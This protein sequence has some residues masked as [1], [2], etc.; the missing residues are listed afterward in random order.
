M[1]RAAGASERAT[2]SVGMR[3]GCA[4]LLSAGGHAGTKCGYWAAASRSYSGTAD[5][6]MAATSITSP[7]FHSLGGL[8][9]NE[10]GATGSGPIWI[11]CSSTSRIIWCLMQSTC[12]MSMLLY[13]ELGSAVMNV[14]LPGSMRVV[15]HSVVRWIGQV[16]SRPATPCA[17]SVLSGTTGMPRRRQTGPCVAPRMRQEPS[18]CL[19]KPCCLR[20]C[21]AACSMSMH[22]VPSPMYNGHAKG[23]RSGIVSNKAA[24]GREAGLL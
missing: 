24:T 12:G 10:P 16:E 11:A 9:H 14:A 6:A 22:L 7:S 3:E 18:S 20:L 17:A 13:G 19:H 1:C 23:I 15:S 8:R 2:V 5:S 4:S 21:L